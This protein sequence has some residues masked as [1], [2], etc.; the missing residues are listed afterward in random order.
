MFVR[1]QRCSGMY[2]FSLVDADLGTRQPLATTV[3]EIGSV[4]ESMLSS[5]Q[6]WYAIADNLVGADL[7]LEIKRRAARDLSQWLPPL[8]RD[9]LIE[10]KISDLQGL[11][12]IGS[13][14]AREQL[15]QPVLLSEDDPL[16]IIADWLSQ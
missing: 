14:L 11:A 9:I 13:E 7:E 5:W 6:A 3:V 1:V 16:T 8:S 15:A 4:A 2:Q 10:N 12:D